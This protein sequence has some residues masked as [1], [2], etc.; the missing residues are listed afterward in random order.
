MQKFKYLLSLR[1]A[2]LL[3]VL[4]SCCALIYHGLI[5]SQIID[6]ANTWGGRLPDEQTMRIFE[7]IS[8]ITQLAFIGF[9]YSRYN[10]IGGRRIQ[11]VLTVIFYCIA[12]L[13]A[14]N[15]IGNLL[16]YS[17]LETLIFTP[18]TFFMAIAA[19]RLAQNDTSK[20]TGPN[21]K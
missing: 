17:T 9:A 18:V 8:V 14:L 13:L 12:A 15:T 10:H 1:T 7:T 5:L 3:F 11:T 6:Y 2:Y 20:R 19:L 4:A 16:S 21:Q